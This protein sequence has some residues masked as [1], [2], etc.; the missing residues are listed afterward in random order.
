MT[1]TR[2]GRGAAF[3]AA[4]L[5]V[6][7]PGLAAGEPPKHADSKVAAAKLTTERL[8]VVSATGTHTFDVEIA[9]TAQQQALGLMFRTSLAA[10]KGMLFHNGKEREITMWMKNTYIPLDMVFIRADGTVHRIA[11]RTEPFSERMISSEG[12]VSGVLE[13]AGG[14]AEQLG[15]KPGDK[16]RHRLF[17]ATP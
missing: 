14:R 16:V 6:L 3:G 1:E 5:A 11:A 2:Y 15:L 17:G 13:I 8:D 10:D 12:L 9:T 7:T 4:L